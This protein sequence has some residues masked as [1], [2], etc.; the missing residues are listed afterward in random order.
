M[1]SLACICL[2]KLAIISPNTPMAVLVSLK[3][4]PNWLESKF[5]LEMISKIISSFK[6]GFQ[7]KLIERDRLS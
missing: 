1:E 2:L 4:F 3:K 7:I 5:T 6:F